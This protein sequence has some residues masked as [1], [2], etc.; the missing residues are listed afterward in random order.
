M[1]LR[2]GHR[3]LCAARPNAL[4]LVLIR[5]ASTQVPR[6]SSLEAPHRYFRSISQRRGASLRRLLVKC[7]LS[8]GRCWA[9]PL[10]PCAALRR[11]CGY[12]RTPSLQFRRR[13]TVEH[14]ALWVFEQ[15]ERVGF[16][17]EQAAL[18]CELRDLFDPRE[19]LLQVRPA[20][21]PRLVDIKQLA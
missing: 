12:G 15:I 4:I 20:A 21:G 1:A 16:H 10:P 7:G 6:C 11:A 13:G 8:A 18:A 5:L 14:S 17:R 19:H 2:D 9:A 3:R